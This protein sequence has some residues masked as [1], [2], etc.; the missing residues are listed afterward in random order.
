[1]LDEFRFLF[2]YRRA[3]LPSPISCKMMS[4]LFLFV[5]HVLV[6]L[7]HNH[8]AIASN[9]SFSYVLTIH[10]SYPYSN[11]LQMFVSTKLFLVYVLKFLLI[12]SISFFFLLRQF[13]FFNF[14][15]DLF[16]VVCDS[17]KELNFYSINCCIFYPDVNCNVLSWFRFC[18]SRVIFKRFKTKP[19]S[20]VWCPNNLAFHNKRQKYSEFISS[21]IVFFP[22]RKDVS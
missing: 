22:A 16:I 5:K 18:F 15:V 12:N 6:I 9:L 10:V 17:D 14:F 20:L 8:T 13:F 7:L 4:L 19:M 3:F 1:M 11:I 2:N 21:A